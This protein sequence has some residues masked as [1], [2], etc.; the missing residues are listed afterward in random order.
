MN[1]DNY[2]PREPYARLR[3]G[4][5]SLVLG[6]NSKATLLHSLFQYKF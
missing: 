4:T 1:G 2:K 6:A 5:L 3:T